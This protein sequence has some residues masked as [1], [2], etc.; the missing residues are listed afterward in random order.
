ML[1]KLMPSLPEGDHWRYEVKW[2]GYR[3]I[4]VVEQAKV[5]LWSRNERDLGRRFPVLVEALAKLPCRSAVLDGEVLVL[6]ETGKPDFEA[7]QYFQPAS[8]PRLYFYAFD[9]LHLE[10]V[11]LTGLPLVE[12][13]TPLEALL[14]S[15][16]S[17]VRLSS[18]L[19]GTPETLVPAVRAMGLEGIVAKDARSLYEPGKRSGKWQKFKLNLEEEFVIGGFIPGG[20]GGVESLALGKAE[21]KTLRYVASL[22]LHVPPRMSRELRARLE[23]ISTTRQPFAEIPTRKPGGSWHTGSGMT[24]E[25]LALTRWVDPRYNAE[26]TFL[27]CTKGGFLRHAKVKRML[28][29]PDDR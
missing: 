16:P 2:D 10:G 6:D 12:R 3:C 23:G 11:D 25:E 13:R 29:S 21:G 5:K 7:L 24:A 14:A 17:H 8:S 1:L 27:E 9:L 22:P 20:D 18:S 28:N 26:V 19:D 4:A 15:P